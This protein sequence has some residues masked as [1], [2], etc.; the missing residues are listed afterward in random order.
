MNI[1]LKSTVATL[2]L[3]IIA[4]PPFSAALDALA[5]GRALS[6]D[7]LGTG[8][9]LEAV[10]A[11][12]LSFSF[13][14][15]PL[16]TALAFTLCWFAS[17][18]FFASEDAKQRQA[19]G[20]VLGNARI[21]M[22]AEAIRASDT[23]DGKS[24]PK[25]RGYVY[26]YAKG[27]YLYESGTPHV[28]CVGQTGSGKTRFQNIP[29][30]DLLTYGKEG[31]N[32]VVSDVKNELVELCGDALAERGYKVLLLDV[33]HPLR[34]D[35]FNPLKLVCDL[36]A[37]DDMREAEQAAEDFAAALVPE[38]REGQTSH[39]ITSARGILAA[40][41]LYV[42]VSEDCPDGCKHMATVCRIVN[43][44]TEGAG[45]DPTAPLKALFRSLP[46]GHPARSFASQFLSSGGNE[47]RSIVS[48]LKVHL[49]PYA[50][51]SLAWLTSGSDID[52]RRVLTDKTALFLHVMDEGSPYNSLFSVFI[53]QLYKAV[54]SV[55]DRNGGKLPRRCTVLG[56]EW[57][58]LPTQRCLPSLLSLGR[59]YGLHWYGSL[60]A[61]SQLDKYGQSQK[62]TILA[63]CGV[64][65]ALKV[66]EG[67]REYF[68]SLVG[69]TTRHTQGTN[70]S[71][72]GRGS[73]SSTSY[74]EH[75]DDVI[76]SW[77]WLSMAPA[78]QGCVV[79]KQA[80]ND[81]PP[82]HAG[83]LNAPLVDCTLTPTKAHFG[84]GAPEHEAAK[85]LSYQKRLDARAASR[86]PE[87]ET[88][89]PVWPQGDRETEAPDDE[90]SA[91]DDRS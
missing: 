32:V 27:C 83:V 45:E 17:L 46:Q 33:Q 28:I 71:T 50:S 7:M 42:A 44:G 90:W 73:S 61:T 68:S 63:N 66:A 54:H 13:F 91:F 51:S 69:K 80:E 74:S 88:W 67:D 3:S 21:K 52:P 26:G 40:T 84:L 86:V 14:S 30:L 47:L 43:E 89:C 24:E 37:E 59:S 4:C 79:C 57:G 75:A 25:S 87:V 20:G 23:W 39:W 22:G 31:V 56:D 72:S 60:Q 41:A 6:P 35:R 82:N 15:Y 12:W 5:T 48:T 78:Q 9:S 29:S 8:L 76:H 10:P 16:G 70:R 49:R 34:G 1:L 85:R 77:E 62:Q 19:D 58:N 64:K 11:W 55:A 65:V 81:M 36:A 38:E 53:D 2:P 18:L